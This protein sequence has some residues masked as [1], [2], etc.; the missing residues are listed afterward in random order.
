VANAIFDSTCAVMLS[1]ETAVGRYPVEAVATM[2]AIARTVEAEIEREGRAPQ[3]WALDRDSIS[4]A[5]SFGACDVARKM[6]AA[7][8]VT[9]TSS[10]A[11]AR[12]VARYRPSQP[13]I[14]VSPHAETVRRLSLVWG[15]TALLGGAEGDA[16][17]VI[18][19]AV[20]RAVAAGLVEAGDRVVVT[21]GIHPH[22]SGA[23][24]L[25]Q[26]RVVGG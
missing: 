17:A 19:D 20:G 14:A 25:I 23:T 21:A 11:T 8:I 18:D 16:D 3:S 13:I 1:G 15:V 12:S 9:A 4:G 26:A 6:G 2:A 22:R 24:N 7:A 5:I 10:G